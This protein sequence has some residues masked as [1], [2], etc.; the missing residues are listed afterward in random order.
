MLCIIVMVVAC[1]VAVVVKLTLRLL[2]AVP[3]YYISG[4]LKGAGPVECSA[5]SP[6][7]MAWSLLVYVLF[8]CSH[9]CLLL[10]QPPWPHQVMHYIILVAN[11]E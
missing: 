9:A 6:F 10:A 2:C 11:H 7:H 3:I 1:S 5:F 8:S 4:V